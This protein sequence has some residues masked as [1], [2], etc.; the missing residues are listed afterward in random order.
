M[1]TS[2]SLMVVLW[3]W[4][5]VPSFKQ[6]YLSDFSSRDDLLDAALASAHVPFLLNWSPVAAARGGWFVDGSLR[7]FIKYVL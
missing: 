1:M 3:C 4:W 2:R 6:Q 5:Q 7:D